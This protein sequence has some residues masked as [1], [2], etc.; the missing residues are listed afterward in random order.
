MSKESKENNSEKLLKA[1][2]E[3]NALIIIGLSVLEY[4]IRVSMVQVFESVLGPQWLSHTLMDQGF[5]IFKEEASIIT[6]RKSNQFVLTEKKFIEESSMGFWVELLNRET[7][8][9][10]KG[11]PIQAFKYRPPTIKRSNIYHTFKNLKDLRNRLVHNRFLLDSTK[12]ETPLLLKTLQKADEDTRT[13]ISYINP[14]ALN[15]LP[16]KIDEKISELGKL[17]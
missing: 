17:L 8:K 7:Y 12:K 9:Q 4:N 10:L 3:L 2:L 11:I 6:K 1:I 5:P 13:L 16:Q 15:L 14:S